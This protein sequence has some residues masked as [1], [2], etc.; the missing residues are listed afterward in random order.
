MNTVFIILTVCIAVVLGVTLEK[1]LK[2]AC[3]AEEGASPDA[4]EK[5]YQRN[6]WEDDSKLRCFSV[7]MMRKW[8]LVDEPDGSWIP[9]AISEFI[10]KTYP[11]ANVDEVMTKCPLIFDAT[12][13]TSY[14]LQKC[15]GDL[16][17]TEVA[18]TA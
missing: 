9:E 16:K 10:S 8:K 6:E 14:L 11:S 4:V 7:C 17:L 5:A 13:T 1:E 2:D 3:I 18:T 12:C 15:W